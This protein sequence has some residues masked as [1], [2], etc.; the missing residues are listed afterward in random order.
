MAKPPG[1]LVC[2]PAPRLLTELPAKVPG[3]VAED[4]HMLR[5]LYTR[6]APAWSA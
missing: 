6:E 4:A 1:A 2:I 5:A 3:K